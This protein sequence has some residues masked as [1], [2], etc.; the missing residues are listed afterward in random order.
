MRGTVRKKAMVES[1]RLFA[2][3]GDALIRPLS[4]D[5]TVYSVDML[6]SEMYSTLLRTPIE[7]EVFCFEM[8]HPILCHT[9]GICHV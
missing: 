1:F 5:P 9:H 2:W 4:C 3:L 6:L 8:S 7:P